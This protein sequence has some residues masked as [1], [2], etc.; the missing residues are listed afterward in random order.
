[1][2]KPDFDHTNL[3]G[4]MKGVIHFCEEKIQSHNYE[5]EPEWYSRS[6]YVTWFSVKFHADVIVDR[7]VM[8][9]YCL[10]QSHALLP[11][12]TPRPYSTIYNDVQK[13]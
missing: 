4:M 8:R 6:M 9:L 3:S 5:R 7:S 10:R 11:A 1:M 2:S 13:L 12:S